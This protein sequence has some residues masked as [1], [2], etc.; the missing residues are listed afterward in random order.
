M[1]KFRLFTLASVIVLAIIVL[2][3]KYYFQQPELDT[4]NM[5]ATVFNQ[6]RSLPNFSL[7]DDKGERFTESNLRGQWNLLF[8]GFSHCP[9]L[10]P[11]TL[12][13]LNKIVT[14]I[15]ADHTPRV[16][17]ITIDPKRD[18]PERLHEY[19]PRFNTQFVGV[20]GNEKTLKRLREAMGVLTMPASQT[21]NQGNYNID[22]SGSIML[23][24]PT[25]KLYA[26]FN[27]PHDVDTISKEIVMLQDY[28]QS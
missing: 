7:I 13:R 28:R 12:A 26:V 11:T 3:N 14:Q 19:L 24:D 23:V 20:T 27:T 6:A 16:I 2:G 22:H 17:F 25:G 21:D 10:C 8:F 1:K 15:P 4:K 9:G 5:T 18:N